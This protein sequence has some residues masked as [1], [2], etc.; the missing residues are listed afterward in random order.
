MKFINIKS[1]ALLASAVAL[2]GCGENAWN[3]NLDGFEVPPVYSD[4]ETINYTLTAADYSTL[5]TLPANTA[6]AATQEEKTALK[7]IGTNHCFTS[8]DEAR[9]YL[10]AFFAYKGFP[11]FTLNDGSSIKVTYA[12][13][14]EAP[15]EVVA[16][17]NTTKEYRVS[18][19]DY[20][21]VWG[22][23]EDYISAF[24]PMNPASANLPALL[25]AAYPDAQAGDYVVANYNEANTN[26]IFGS[27]NG[28]ET[29]EF[30]LTDVIGK[31]ASGDELSVKGIVTGISTRG[32]VITDNSGSICYDSGSNTF[33]DDLITIGAQV[34]ASGTVSTYNRCLQIGKDQS[35]TVVGTGNYTYPAPVIY[36]GAK[37]T[38]A[39][40]A[41]GDLLAQYVQLE[42]TLSISG[43]YY[44]IAIEGT[45][46]QGSVYYAP[47]YIKE[48]LTDGET[49]T[50]T[51][52]FVAVTGKG[53]YFNILLTGVKGKTTT[54]RA[55]V[56]VVETVGKNAIY[57]FDGSK[58]SVPASTLVLQP[59][60]YVA[61]QQKYGNLSGT[62]PQTLLPIYLKQTLP[63]AQEEDAEIVAYKYY[64]GST[65]SYEASKFEFA[66]GE[67]AM[68]ANENLVTDRFNRINGKWAFDPSVTLTLP[69]GR[70]QPLST[71]YFQA[72]VDWVY[73]NIDKPLGATSITSGVGYVTSYG[74]NEYYS[75]ASA[76]QGNVD[77]RASAAL[78]QY[79]E[80][81]ANM[82][83]DEIVETMKS[84][85]CYKT[86]PAALAKIH[87][88]AVPI[89][90]MEV[91][92]TINF[93]AYTGSATEYQVVYKVV[94][95][96][97]FEFVSCNWWADGVGTHP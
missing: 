83:D 78:T 43:N 73:E 9:K 53:Q 30:E 97:Q 89:E 92:Y 37:V 39:C 31:A 15:K 80:G 93:T 86:F 22:S 46:K 66:N 95:P 54:F 51:G 62:L 88:D 63:Y 74:N 2:T 13:G 71:L 24:A 75:G 33:A 8:E 48:Q 3:N 59:A 67:W 38:A 91:L 44:N 1:L 72:C 58:W 85:F 96:A 81:Y 64:N 94:G 21:G 10:P 40:D 69:A 41:T 52:Y 28:G 7:A 29:P 56:G 23:D 5:S 12:V 45:E 17:N 84:R 79:P 65:T 60:D 55:P 35:Y 76:Y 87:S 47:S 19:E 4:T 18:E 90:G 82:S 26:P 61:M 6:L 50:F 36:D 34:E 68:A 25:K 77:I 27:V 20:I 32:F 70:S 42:G 57:C 16:I 49:Y 11:Y 14:A